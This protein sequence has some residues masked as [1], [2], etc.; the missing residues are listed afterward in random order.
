[1]SLASEVVSNALA[2][3]LVVVAFASC[4]LAVDGAWQVSRALAV[5]VQDLARHRSL[6]SANEALKRQNRVILELAAQRDALREE[7]DVLEDQEARLQD[8]LELGKV[9]RGYLQMDVLHFQEECEK[10]AEAFGELQEAFSA[11]LQDYREL[12]P[13]IPARM[14]SIE[15][16]EHWLAYELAPPKD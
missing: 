9:N 12:R 4:Y 10:A 11:M 1:M 7:V 6:R 5:W 8:A 13:R 14:E 15:T 16:M 2:L 3:T